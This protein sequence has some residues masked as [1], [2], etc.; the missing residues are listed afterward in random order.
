MWKDVLPDNNEH[1]QQSSNLVVFVLGM[2][3]GMILVIMI[4]SI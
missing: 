4:G 1:K 2:I 3:F